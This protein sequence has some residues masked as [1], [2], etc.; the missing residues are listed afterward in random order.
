MYN[1]T[2]AA[3]KCVN[4]LGIEKNS[5]GLTPW[6]EAPYQ[7]ISWW[8]ME[9]FSALKFYHMAV[10]LEKLKNQYS[11]AAKKISDDFSIDEDL[12]KLVGKLL[13]SIK[14]ECLELSLS[15]SA[16]VI[17][18]F[19]H[20]LV[21]WKIGLLANMTVGQMKSR[22][23]EINRAIK[24]EMK[25]HLFMYIPVEKVKYY[26]SYRKTRGVGQAYL[27]GDSVNNKL[28]D[29]SF[30][31]EEAGNCF[32]TNRYTACVFHLMRAMEKAVQKLGDNLGV[33]LVNEKVWQTIIG[34]IREELKKKFPNSKDSNRIKYENIL[35]HLET[36]KI[37]WRNPTMHPK[38]TYTDEEAYNIMHNVEIFMVDL[39]SIL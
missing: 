18:E 22:L 39:A 2:I 24:R 29:A 16:E 32:A 21:S 9:K 8:D 28:P 26:D 12:R 30:D 19:Q 15:N 33:M 7:L 5:C 38:A 36:V 17:C 37:A 20:D 13:N 11:V 25:L 31:I 34:D 27:F 6:Q 10:L 3:K 35:G 4:N 14:L 1:T 23:D